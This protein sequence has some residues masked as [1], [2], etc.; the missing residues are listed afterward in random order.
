[1]ALIKNLP[2]KSQSAISDTDLLIIED[3]TNTCQ[4]TFES[5][6]GSIEDS[7]LSS[8]NALSNAGFS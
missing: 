6:K 5:I 4:T 7:L 3:D 1:M 8:F 2:E